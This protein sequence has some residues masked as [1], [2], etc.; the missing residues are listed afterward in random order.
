MEIGSGIAHRVREH[1]PPAARKA[2]IVTQ[3]NI[4]IE[5]ET[6]LDQ[7]VFTIGE[8]EEYK[9]LDTVGSLCREWAEWGLN[10]NDVVVGL[11]GGIVTDVAGFAAAVFHR[12]LPV[13]HVS[14]TL[15]GQIDAAIGGKTAVNIPEGKNLVGAFWQPNAV[16]CDVAMLDSLPQRHYRAGLGE[17]AKYHFLD[18]GAMNAL[19]NDELVDGRLSPEALIDRVEA[20]VVIKADAV[21]ADEREGGRRALLNYGHT[22]GHALETVGGHD[23][24]HGEA[25]AIGIGY[26]ATV[27]NSLGRIDEQRVDEHQ[28]VLEGYGLPTLPESAHDFDDLLAVMKRDKKALTGG[29]TFILDGPQ[30]PEVVNDVDVS[31][32]EASY[33]AWLS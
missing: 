26:A 33:E 24:L 22:L 17:M 3:S 29:V 28:Q 7:Q 25:V 20:S 8:G 2:A 10:R 1:L 11:G 19:G 15:L 12:G 6:G 14:T 5:L 13:I 23:L 27:A 18:D 21:A 9:S 16:I 32:L 31:I 30:G 4:G